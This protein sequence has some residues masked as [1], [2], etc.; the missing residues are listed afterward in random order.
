MSGAAIDVT[1]YRQ[2]QESAGVEF[3]DELVDTFLEEAPRMIAAIRLAHGQRD[4][5]SFRR[6]AH[7]LKSNCNT[8]GALALAAQARDIELSG[9]ERYPASDAGAIDE[10]DRS[11][12]GVARALADLRH[13]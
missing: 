6:Q 2:L 13:E 3:V 10:L 11:Y 9:I 5:D 4:A 7:S 12:A 8:F 1:V